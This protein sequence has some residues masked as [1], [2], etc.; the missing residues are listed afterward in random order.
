VTASCQPLNEDES[1]VGVSP[2]GEAWVEGSLGVRVISPDGSSTPIDAGFTEADQLV[3]WGASSAFVVGDNSLWSTTSTGTEA[4]SLPPELGKP[5]FVCGDP[6]N[7]G[8]SF[9]VTTR[10]LFERRAEAWLRWDLPIELIESMEIRD[11]QGACSGE[12]AVLYLEA[13]E[14][15]WEL[16]YGQA[17][18]YRHAATLTDVTETD[19]D[20]RV[21]FV[22]IRN[23]ELQRFDGEGW[24]PIP[25]DEGDV[26]RV[27][28]ADGV[29]WASV[30][31]TLFRRDRFERWQRLETG[32]WP[33]EI[34]VLRGYAAGSAWLV[35]A[36]QLCHVEYPET[37]RVDGV[38]PYQRFAE[39]ATL[40]LAVSSDPAMG[41]TLSA[42]L[43]GHALAVSGSAGSWTVTGMTALGPGWHSLVFNVAKPGAAAQRTVKFL[44]EGDVVG[45]PPPNPTVSWERDIRPLYEASC[46]VCHGEGGN[47]TFLGSYEAFS[48]LGQ[49]ALDLV[50]SGEMPPASAGGLAEPLTPAE[51]QVLETWVQEG[52]GP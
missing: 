36:E 28:A 5:R 14:S 26:T 41:A 19:V 35:N 34:R 31:G 52:M 46:A 13:G 20:V 11:L 17:A 51:T 38:R 27:S 32:V 2:E 23:G 4:L 10:G 42:H 15:V 21:G 25:F 9:V 30:G 24:V 43:D 1:L 37:L 8:G 6:R 44:V 7:A 29:L 50:K 49:L 12:Q 18:S 40:T 33:S 48:A 47:Q 45:P 22:A 16:R 3:A 39:G